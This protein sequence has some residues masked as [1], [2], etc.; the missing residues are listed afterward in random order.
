VTFGSPT[1]TTPTTSFAPLSSTT[2]PGPAPFEA[3]IPLR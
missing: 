2:S 1:V 3:T